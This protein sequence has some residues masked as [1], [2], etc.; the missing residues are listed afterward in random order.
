MG[1]EPADDDVFEGALGDVD[2]LYDV[3]CDAVGEVLVVV[4]VVAVGVV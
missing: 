1:E 3:W 4:D 2:D